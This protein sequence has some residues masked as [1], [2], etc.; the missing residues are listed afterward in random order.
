MSLKERLAEDMKT[1]LKSRQSV[2][3]STIRM[4]LAAIKNK[5]IDLRR[6]LDEREAIECV[7]SQARL[8]K[9]AIE[10]FKLGRRQDL[11]EKEEQELGY[12][13]SYLP[14]Q[15]TAAEIASEVSRA[16]AEAQAAGLKDLGQVMRILIPRIS[17]K[18][19]NRTVSELAKEML[20]KKEG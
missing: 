15:L 10:Q 6:E 17:G 14:S 16:I 9:E 20:A 12:L 2:W 3:L 8:R 18:A 19:D 5:E 11:V 13:Q 1:A 7:V 4:L